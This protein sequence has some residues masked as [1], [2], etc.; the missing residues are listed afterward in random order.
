LRGAPGGA[1]IIRIPDG[2]L[3]GIDLT[4]IV[5]ANF[6]QADAHIIQAAKERGFALLTAQRAFAS[7]VQNPSYPER[8]RQWGLVNIVYAS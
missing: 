3:S 1:K 7:Q 8:A 2:N 6:D 5:T 4:K